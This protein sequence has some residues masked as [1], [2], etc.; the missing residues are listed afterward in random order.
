VSVGRGGGVVGVGW[1]GG[2]GG[3]LE[4]PE[5]VAGRLHPSGARLRIVWAIPPLLPSPF[6]LA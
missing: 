6:V 2:G 5:R 4:Q 3:G 1:W